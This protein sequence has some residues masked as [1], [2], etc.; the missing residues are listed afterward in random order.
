MGLFGPPNVER[1][2]ARGDVPG[3]VNALGYEKDAG[4]REAAA[5]ALAR[6]GDPAAVGPLFALV[7]DRHA[8]Q[9]C[10][11]TAAEALGEIGAPAVEFLTPALQD[12]SDD[13]REAATRVLGNVGAPAFAALEIALKDSSA[14]VRETAIKALGAIGGA[15]AVEILNVALT[16]SSAAVR[17]SAAR[18]LAKVGSAPEGGQAGAAYYWVEKRDWNEC[19]RLGASA[20]EPLVAALKHRDKVVRRAA[21]QALGK[22]ADPR[23]AKG[24]VSALGDSDQNVRQ[25]AAEALVRI[26]APAAK[27]L[28]AAL[29]DGNATRRRLAREVLDRT[30]WSPDRSK[31]GASYWIAKRQWDRCV[32]IGAPAVAPLL[33]ALEH[34]DEWGRGEAALALGR[35][36]NPR[37]AE[38]LRAALNDD[39]E[40]VRV[41]A[42]RAL[43]A[44]SESAGSG[45][46]A[47]PA[48][49][50]EE[51]T[52][53]IRGQRAVE[54]GVDADTP[55]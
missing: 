2:E 12:S 30:G 16:D 23:S 38:P 50:G 55:R 44:L 35:I 53:A 20:V 9:P 49:P 41:C 7:L 4:V 48:G 11:Q 27:P 19:V 21:A 45:E 29:L 34:D 43:A 28:T 36:G 39:A 51:H 42:A 54:V 13:V 6:S 46:S 18:A 5:R 31:A 33:W 8:P 32:E 3:L 52:A 26:M 25:A 22:I 40:H 37:V 10:R 14:V 1:L 17:Q 24:L 15:P 47:G